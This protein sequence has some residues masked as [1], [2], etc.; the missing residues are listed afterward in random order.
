MSGGSGGARTQAPAFA[1]PNGGLRPGTSSSGCLTGGNQLP[2]LCG[3]DP[4]VRGETFQGHW[5]QLRDIA[6]IQVRGSKCF[7]CGR[8]V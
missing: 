3:E 2:A 6:T 4:L 1:A 7:H 8:T 5:E